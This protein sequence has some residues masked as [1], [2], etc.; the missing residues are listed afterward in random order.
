MRRLL[1]AAALAALTA[2]AVLRLFRR[3]LGAGDAR[4]L[5]AAGDEP[6]GLLSW[7]AARRKAT[8]IEAQLTEDERLSLLVGRGFNRSG[9]VGLTSAVPRLG[10][11]ALRM[12]DASS[13]FRPLGPGEYGTVT[14]WPSLLAMASTWDEVAVWR[15]ASAVAAE[16]R[17]KGANVLL[18]PGLNVHRTPWGGRNWE[19]LSGEDPYLG[20]RLAP[21]YIRAIQSA[22]V[23]ATIKH[24]A[25]NQQETERRRSNAVVAEKTA[26]ELYFPP[27]EAAIGAGAGAVM[28]SYN[29]F[30]GSQA[31]GSKALLTDILRG[32]LGFAGFVMSDWEALM[33]TDALEAGVDMEQSAP[34]YFAK[35]ELAKANISAAVVSQAAWRILTSIYHLR[36]DE[37]QGCEFP[38]EAER[39]T[40]VRTQAHLQLAGELAAEAVVLLKNSND[41]LP[42]LHGPIR[43]LAV[44]GVAAEAGDTMNQW[45]PGSPYSGGGSGHVASPDVV[46]PLAGIQRR[47]AIAG[48]RVVTPS[49]ESSRAGRLAAALEAASHADVVIVV[50][51]AT[52]SE[53]RDRPD[54]S[55]ADG[56]DELIAAVAAEGKPVV[57]LLQVPGP[58]LTPWRD[59]VAA[60]AVLFLGGERTGSAWA[61]VLF[62]DTAPSGKLPVTMP[63]NMSGLIRPQGAENLTYSE[64][65]ATSYRSSAIAAAF[66]FGH[67]VS[68]TRFEFGAPR[69]LMAG[70]PAAICVRLG[71]TNI[72]DRAGR[73]VVQAYITFLKV[74]GPR[75]M[76]GFTKTSLLQP[77]ETEEVTLKFSQRDLSIYNET[78]GGW[79]EHDRLLV[80]IG[81]SSDDVQHTLFLPMRV[82]ASTR[83]QAPSSTAQP[84]AYDTRGEPMPHSDAAR[85]W[86][87]LWEH[88]WA[89]AVAAVLSQQVIST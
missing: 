75:T 28:C 17:A 13:G 11:P 77:G 10:I 49:R 83:Y 27:F 37:Q 60:L 14:S 21:A 19:Y 15:M 43:T 40:N 12:Q 72:G 34:K 45:G 70:C 71:I 85:G 31:C 32:R 1:G 51:A 59:E 84:F 69:L 46:T 64:G 61:S 30:N 78:T 55:L 63:A 29:R 2:S 33:S 76:R 5:R 80:Q 16:F 52:A 47:A 86:R 68:Y 38:C 79:D 26:W 36:L 35:R 82:D 57:V 50:G 42:L 7:E 23:M 39:A 87:M 66:P 22:G 24:F 9:W 81:A 3:S 8:E 73:E 58:V 65:L 20:S 54:L 56:A 25:F 62:G 89:V 18:G 53:D 44:V 4:R 41:T 6:D 74:P 67:G 48:I 88:A